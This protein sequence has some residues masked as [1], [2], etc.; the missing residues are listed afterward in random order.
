MKD[1]RGGWLVWRRPV[2]L[3][4]PVRFSGR[5]YLLLGDAQEYGAPKDQGTVR[6][7]GSRTANGSRLH[8]ERKGAS[9]AAPWNVV[10][11]PC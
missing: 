7:R 6:C 10:V 3:R 2:R 11:R 4:R 8:R 1:A 9:W 5:S